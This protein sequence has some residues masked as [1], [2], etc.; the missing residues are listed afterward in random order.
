MRRFFV[1]V[2][3][4][5]LLALPASAATFNVTDLGDAPD[6]TPGDGFCATAGA[7]CTL[8]AAIEENNALGGNTVTFL[9][10]G[11]I[12][13]ATNLPSITNSLTINGTSVPGYTGTP[14]MILDGA[15]A[16]TVGFN[17]TTGSGSLSGFEVH[18]FTSAAVSISSA[19]VS[20]TKNY[21]GPIS[22]GLA[23]GN[24]VVLTSTSATA[25]I[26]ASGAGNVISGN[27]SNGLSV[28]GTGHNIT[29]NRIGTNAA[30]TAALPNGSDG[31]HVAGSATNTIF[32]GTFS[33]PNDVN[34]ISGNGGNG[35][36]I[37]LATGVTVAGN[38][39]GTDATGAT[40]I[41]NGQNGVALEAGQANFIGQAD[42][43]NVIS[44]N[45]LNG[46]DVDSNSSGNS[47]I[48]NTIGLDFSGTALLSNGGSG[49][50][51]AGLNTIIGG[52]T[53]RNII[54]G[55]QA[56]G[57]TLV[58]SATGTTIKGNIIG[59]DGDGAGIL[60]NVVHG[61]NIVSATNI[62]IG[63]T[64]A[65]EGNLISGN[66]SD[67]IHADNGSQ[68][69]VYGNIIGLDG[70]GTSI[71]GNGFHGIDLNGTLTAN[72]GSA[73]AGA[74]NLVSGN[75]DVGILLE[76][77]ASTI[78]IIGNFV[79]TDISGTIAE[80][81]LAEGIELNP[82]SAV[83]ISG[84]VVSGNGFDGIATYFSSNS[85]IYG[86]TIGRN[87]ANTTDLGNLLS[88]VFICDGSSNITVGS[89]ALGGNVISANGDT[90]LTITKTANG[91]T[92][93]A[94]SIFNN[95]KLGIDLNDDGVSP[96]DAQDPDSGPNTMQNSP[97]ITGVAV[98]VSSGTLVQGTFNSTPSTSFT[99]HFYSNNAAD[100]SGFGE[101]ET[102]FGSM[103]A[104]T[105]ASGNTTFSFTSPTMAAGFVTATATGPNGVSE[106]SN[107]FAVAGVPTIQFSAPSYAFGE[108]SGSATITVTRS[109]NTTVSST[110]AY[111]TSNGTATQPGDYLP[112][113]GT[114]T[115][116]AG[117][118]SKTFNVTIINDTVDE[119]D[120]TVNL[121]LSS[122]TNATLGAQSTA[123]LTIQ[124]DDPAPSI[125]INDVSLAEG[126]SGTTPFTFTVTLSNPSAST[127]T[128]NYA[129]AP[130]TATAGSDYTTTS[131]T[132]T[133]NPLVTTQQLTVN[134]IGDTT[135]EPNETFFV[136]L[137]NA[138]N[139]A[140]TDGQGLG[141]IINDEPSADLS[142][143]KTSNATTFLPG[144]QVTYTITVTN[145]GPSAATG[146]TVT[147]VLPAGATFVSATSSTF[148]CSGTT[149]VT[150]TAASLAV[151]AS[152]TISLVL[153]LSG[154]SAI[155]NSASVSAN[156]PDPTPINNSAAAVV[157]PGA[158][159]PT[160]SEWALLIL[161]LG[162][163]AIAATKVR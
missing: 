113:S 99:L 81:N 20:I 137:S 122:P 74:G 34:V 48:D 11:T 44:G 116:A 143:T 144:Q 140:I 65:G 25:S 89:V 155:S 142:I 77:N 123:V 41:A 157:L 153:R 72:I 139:A 107:A 125:T 134:V 150:C 33:I 61:I 51:D 82:A 86:N 57:I 108:S 55:N 128:V 58:A 73:A 80:G 131:N 103:P 60:G 29:A 10:A 97:V 75:S 160:L 135:L 163:A 83:V 64:Q 151:S 66:G 152:G 149:T 68:I 94:N 5:A 78:N 17:F 127:I 9:L 32:I 39:I 18:G 154:S 28:Q 8:R 119:P 67:G 36:D 15:G 43:V 53:D 45:T 104:T 133:F 49:I 90:G 4:V 12:T 52:A 22:G 76:G 27:S 63:G 70:P 13:P 145:A 46:V 111:A 7:V 114:I 124:D 71:V 156:E 92:A 96:N 79:G 93:A 35:I 37:R 14:L 19:N 129:T 120:E 161:A 110:V 16:R 38:F 146:V 132:L 42:S 24:G 126:N 21:L 101:G 102:Y 84:N 136:N 88:G 148:S 98:S 26:G 87:A 121:T 1:V 115:F 3:L 162:L 141:T 56:D 159:I 23:N 105:D 158:T 130:G 147:D 118:T 54:S 40:A 6:A 95:A 2:S 100:P 112:A 30:G 106:F 85:Q 91:I 31:I 69:N 59:L 117:D 50:S 138:T 109:G 62:T 47:I